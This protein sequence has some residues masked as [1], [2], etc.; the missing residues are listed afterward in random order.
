MLQANPHIYRVISYGADPTGKVDS[1]DAIERAIADA[2]K[3]PGNGFLINGVVNLGG[4]Q[5]HLEG[6]HY[7]V[8]RPL[9][10]PAGR[11]NLMVCKQF[12]QF[13]FF[14]QEKKKKNLNV[15]KSSFMVLYST[16]PIFQLPFTDDFEK[17]YVKNT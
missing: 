16:C 5:I 4:V 1:T 2:V 15:F 10:F 14:F 8:S 7:M 17:S 12:P 13:F 11:G 6:G 3:D 9:K